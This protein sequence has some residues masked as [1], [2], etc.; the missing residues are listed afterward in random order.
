MVKGVARKKELDPRDPLW[1]WRLPKFPK[2]SN[3]K[4]VGR[5]KKIYAVMREMYQKS[6]VQRNSQVKRNGDKASK[7]FKTGSKKDVW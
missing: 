1:M 4:S 5:I 2:G 6:L 3:P 7:G